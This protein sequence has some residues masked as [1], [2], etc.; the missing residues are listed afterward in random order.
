MF[1]NLRWDDSSC[2]YPTSG[3]ITSTFTRGVEGSAT[4]RFLG[5]EDA[6]TAT[7]RVAIGDDSDDI[8]IK[9]NCE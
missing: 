5:C 7:I 6:Y 9:D 3:T 8:E 2:C 1:R 4:V